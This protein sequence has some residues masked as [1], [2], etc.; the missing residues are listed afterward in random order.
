[1]PLVIYMVFLIVFMLYYLGHSWVGF[2]YSSKI[3]ISS[4]VVIEF[5]LCLVKWELAPFI[6]SYLGPLLSGN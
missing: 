3:M 1:M 4:F 5:D 6:L 2:S